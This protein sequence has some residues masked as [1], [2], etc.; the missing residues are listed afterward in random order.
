MELRKL[1][2]AGASAGAGSPTL[3]DWLSL[4]LFLLNLVVRPEREI[5]FYFL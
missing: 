1:A 2:G 3:L 5:S 4:E